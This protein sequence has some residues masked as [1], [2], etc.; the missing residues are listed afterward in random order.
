MKCLLAI[1]IPAPHRLQGQSAPATM[2][3][4]A[5]DCHEGLQ[6]MESSPPLFWGVMFCLVIV[7]LGAFCLGFFGGGWGFFSVI[8][9]TEF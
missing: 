2:Q 1:T 3:L 4:L 8:K 6:G 9:T 7:L 5:Q